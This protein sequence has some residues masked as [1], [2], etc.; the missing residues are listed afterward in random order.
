MHWGYWGLEHPYWT[1]ER[2]KH[3]RINRKPPP[4]RESSGLLTEFRKTNNLGALANRFA[5][6]YHY[7]PC[8]YGDRHMTDCQMMAQAE[9]I[10]DYFNK[11]KCTFS[12]ADGDTSGGMKQNGIYNTVR[13]QAHVHNS[14]VI[15][16]FLHLVLE[17]SNS[18][19][20]R[21]QTTSGGT[22]SH[23]LG[24]PHRGMYMVRIG[25]RIS[26][27]AKPHA[28]FSFAGWRG[29]VNSAENPLT[30]TVPDSHGTICAVFAPKRGSVSRPDLYGLKRH[31]DAFETIECGYVD[32]DRPDTNFGA[33][34]NPIFRPVALHKP[35]SVAA[36]KRAFLKF[37]V[38]KVP[39]DKSRMAYATI[40]F[41][42]ACER[43]S[44]PI[45]FVHSTD[46]SW[47]RDTLTWN[48]MPK[49]SGAAVSENDYS[50]RLQS[51]THLEVTDYFTSEG[52]GVHS[53]CVS[54][55]ESVPR[56]CDIRITS[57]DIP[58]SIKSEDKPLLYVV[59]DEKVP[60]VPWDTPAPSAGRAILESPAKGGTLPAPRRVSVETHNGKPVNVTQPAYLEWRNG[61]NAQ[62]FKVY[63]GSSP[64]VS[65][66]Q[67]L[68]DAVYDEF[69]LVFDPGQLIPD[70][71]YYWRVDSVNRD[72][73]ETKGELWSFRSG[74]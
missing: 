38:D 40:K 37:R 60:L 11:N 10:L 67:E 20:L 16:R 1:H 63:F 13:Q 15:D 69:D 9:F 39:A 47:K 50:Y 49:R 17:K 74:P 14:P 12:Y 30:V 52:A 44:K 62:R 4:Q 25:D 34:V 57:S 70:K 64:N 27:E 46:A 18:R 55:T 56:K 5:I 73:K 58:N 28:D 48:N 3:V 24:T 43:S 72:G 68:D 41:H 23:T 26:L 6:D 45:L 2:L 66:A 22:V 31:W 65:L 19:Q 8:K 42:N 51:R 59:W 71:R 21:I 7:R 35:T 54:G 32:A 36:E 29:S 61:G 53:F 33:E